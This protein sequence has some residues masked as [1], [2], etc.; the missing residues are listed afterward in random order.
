M[1]KTTTRAE[2]ADRP[3]TIRIVLA[4]TIVVSALGLAAALPAA[5]QVKAPSK[6]HIK[7]RAA[8]A[9]VK[10]SP[11]DNKADELN[12]KWLSEF[13][14]EKAAE[15]PAAGA[16][17]PAAA[18]NPAA[19]PAEVDDERVSSVPSMAILPGAG[20]RTVVPGTVRPV[21]ANALAGFSNR[22][23][24]AE[25]PSMK[26]LTE[27]FAGFAGSNPKIEMVEGRTGDGATRLVYASIS[28]GNRKQSYW[29]FTPLDQ[30]EGWFDEHGKRL[31]GS[32]L[33]DPKPDSRISSPFGN[34]RYYGRRSGG[35]FH[36]G[37]DYEGKVG[38][39]ILA[40]AD[41]IINHQGWYFQYGRT[42]KITHA[43][44]FETLYAHMSR[45]VDGIGPGSHVKK[46]EV[47]GY[48]GSTGRS[49]GPHLHFSTIVDGQFVDPMPYL[50]G[51]NSGP[52]V[53]S[54]NSLVAYRKW[55]QDIHNAADG[56]RKGR[57]AQAGDAWS[58]NPF[59][60]GRPDRQL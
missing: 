52:N 25:Q 12:E 58:Q 38:E 44:N 28:E 16:T 21:K 42:V 45:F 18:A 37:I 34:R 19:H 47:I 9:A 39:P 33:A 40:A 48:I 5:A 1:A 23:G 29:W 55:Q 24:V 49:T 13:N 6:N 11:T 7:S 60:A 51:G 2:R 30:P 59:T 54:G 17:A 41:G 26:Y 57:G 14:R 31:G 53:L 27:T 43:D 10:P 22:P 36:N 50:T 56:Q 4:A 3:R 8:A 15:Q 35:G 20:A 32:A 46:G